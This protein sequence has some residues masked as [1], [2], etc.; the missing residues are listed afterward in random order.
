M[1]ILVIADVHGH[2][3]T[4]SKILDSITQPFDVILCPGDFTDMQGTPK[5]FT[6][7]DMA[8]IVIQK[9][10]ATKRPVLGIPGNH[11]P[12]EILDLFEEYGI[13]LHG[14]LRKVA[15]MEFVGFG[16]AETPFNTIFEPTEDEIS[17]GLEQAA[18]GAA[19]QFVLM[20]HNPPHNTILDSVAG[21]KEHVG[22]RAVRQFI[23]KTK[24]ILAVSAHI[25]ENS[26]TDKIGPTV[27]FYPGP[28][29]D[30]RYGL[31]EISGKSVKCTVHTIKP[32][33]S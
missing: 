4:L 8:D 20:V 24:P 23:E 17:R 25:H 26:G 21:G 33:K 14:R 13:G 11:D 7:T 5:D 18:S 29:Y 6:Q 16:G 30:G 22:S 9:L 31:V 10:V 1:N 27:I 19:G 12:Y 32:A 28:A 15:S 2:H 3:E